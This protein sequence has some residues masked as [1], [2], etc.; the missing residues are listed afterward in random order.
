LSFLSQAQGRLQ[1]RK[2][3]INPSFDGGSTSAL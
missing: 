3:F 1:G 2:P